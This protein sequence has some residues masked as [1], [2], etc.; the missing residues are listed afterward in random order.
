M[1]VS[2]SSDKMATMQSLFGLTK[3]NYLPQALRCSYNK[4]HTG[5]TTNTIV[6]FP[7]IHLQFWRL[8][9]CK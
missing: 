9:Y 1:F 3:Q 8:Q 6:S 5:T 7:G 4:L 2:E